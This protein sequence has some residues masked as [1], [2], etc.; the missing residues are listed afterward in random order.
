MK[1]FAQATTAAV[2]LA[3]KALNAGGGLSG[4]TTGLDSTI[5]PAPTGV[6]FGR[7]ATTV[8]VK[9]NKLNDIPGDPLYAPD[10]ANGHGVYEIQVDT[11][12]T[13]ATGNFRS[14]TSTATV[15]AFNDVITASPS[16]YVRVRA[17]DSSGN[18]SAWSA[19]TGPTSPAGGVNDSMIVADLSAAKIQFGVMDGDRIDVNTLK[20]ETLETSTLTSADITLNGGSFRAAPGAFNPGVSGV[21]LLMNSQG[22]R[23]YNGATATIVLDAATGNG[24]FNG[25]ITSTATITGGTIA[26]GTF[27][28]GSITGTTITGTTIT[29][30]I[31][32]TAASPNKR[33]EIA[34]ATN[35]IRFYDSSNT[36][37]GL[38][39][40]IAFGP[41]KG[42]T[43]DTPSSYTNMV[44]LGR[45]STEGQIEL[46]T[47]GST[48]GLFHDAITLALGVDAGVL[49]DGTDVTVLC[50]TGNI[51][52]LASGD[53]LF[54]ATEVTASN[55]ITAGGNVKVANG[56]AGALYGPYGTYGARI[57][58]FNGGYVELGDDGSPGIG[59]L[60][61]YLNSSFVKNFVIDHPTDDDKHLVHTTLEGPENGV[62]YR[63]RGRLVDGSAVIELPSYFEALTS[64]QERTVEI[65]EI[66]N[67]RPIVPMGPTDIVD[68]KFLVVGGPGDDS[69]FFWRVEAIRKDVDLLEVEPLKSDVIVQGDGPY[70]YISHRKV[71]V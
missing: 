25:N 56:G 45:S 53:I 27:S 18:P 61:F 51:G 29:G 37:N 3:E 8:I 15:V 40:S 4:V 33:V 58:A 10:V 17:I 34:A 48:L 46:N 39:D 28:S 71:A 52:L 12:N 22:I 50:G 66:Y 62:Y 36:L 69:E 19:V 65:T 68:G 43:I 1:T 20:A 31:L 7:G 44:V 6:V 32:Q 60:K 70:T 9:F 23:L 42:I 30:G 55:N 67:G 54:D 57:L 21:G 35:Q 26:S 2:K 64:L 16:W 63:G 11:A 13:F 24:F 59:A 41:F 47:P 5:P 14:M 38:L 49:M